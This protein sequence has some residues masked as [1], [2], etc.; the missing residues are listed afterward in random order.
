MRAPRSP[1]LLLAVAALLGPNVLIAQGRVIRGTVVDSSSG[2]PISAANVSVRGTTL[3]ASTGADGRFTI[4]NVPQGDVPVIVRRIGYRAREVVARSGQ[5]EIRVAMTS[6]P[7]QLD[8]VVV[9][10]QATAIERRNLPTAVATVSADEVARVSSQSF[11]HALQGKIPGAVI[12][13]NSGAP[14]GG[15]QVRM[16]GV[17]SINAASEPLYVV[18]G[19][20]VSN[21]A[22]PSNQNAVTNAAGGSNPSLDQDAQVNRVAD[23]NPNDIETVEV[24]KGASASAIYGSRAS[25]GVVLIT[26]K[27]GR[28]G[29][30]EFR[31][32]QRFGW[33]Q[34]SNK[35][36][37][38][39]FNSLAEAVDVWGPS[40]A[41]Y[42]QPGVSYDHEEE[43]AGNRPLSSETLLD[44]SGGGE[45]TRY[46]LSGAWKD[47]GGIIDNTGFERQSL[48]ANIQQQFGSRVTLD[49]G[50]NIIRTLAGRGLTNNDNTT[51]SFYMTL[52]FTPSFVNLRR[53]ATD[54]FPDNPFAASNPLETAALM[55]NHEIVWRYIGS[56]RLTVDAF[57]SQTQN[58]RFTAT[59]GA[60]YFAQKNDLLFP[61]EL[62][63]ED[64][65]GQPGTSL[66]SNSDNLNLNFSANG[67]HTF[68]PV[69]WGLRATTS[70]GL[71]FA[72]RDLNVSR[73]VSRSLVGGLEIVDAGTSVRVREF[74]QRV[75]DFGMF[76][77]EEVLLLGERLLLTAGLLADRS[78]V[79][80]DDDK[81]YLYP[82]VAASYRIPRLLRWLDELKLR[83][84]YG[85]TGNQ[86]L[87]GQKFTPL[88]ATQNLNGLPTL[89]VE[90]TI[91]ADNLRPERQRELEGGFDATFA[92]NRGTLEFSVF[93]KTVSD[94]LLERT[95][96]ASTGFTTH[97]FNGGRLRT[98]GV[99]VGLGVVPI[100]TR[101][102]QWVFRSTYFSNRSKIVDL[103]VPTFRAGGFGTALGAFQI[104]EGASPTQIV[105]NDT[106][107]SG[108]DTVR[109]IADANPD[110][111]MSF[112]SDLTYKRFRLSG[113]LDWQQGGA[114]I[115]LTKFLYD[116]GQ[117]TADYAVPITVGGQQ[118]TVG[119]HRLAVWPR[120]TA[121]YVEDGSFV[122]LRELTLSYDVPEQIVGRLW[123]QA[124]SVQLSVSGRNLI[125]WTDYTGLDPEVSNFGN[126][127]IARQI[128]VAPFPPS[129]SFWFGVQ[130]GF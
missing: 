1:L 60:D 99:E 116:L 105:G 12:Q 112:S 54:T 33:Y 56:G 87:Y 57:N 75:E 66:L 82:K 90:G 45:R 103:P 22:I 51:V 92:D 93:Q 80:S 28:S 108:A 58:L 124:R 126:Q 88:A 74:R 130:V 27:R 94:L 8:V 65:D 3:G 44:F 50:S 47:D 120:Q 107:P 23:L 64:D 118:T 40:A 127:N 71:N 29:R 30:P 19:V 119:A 37:A 18:D 41:N 96:A 16:R 76:A 59:A 111:V 38:R 52:P 128:D 48:R 78:S 9:S 110:F 15:V 89:V 113:L 5:E 31:L 69:R 121:V 81:L 11:E 43:L 20:V 46:Y 10:G 17:T 14:G 53:T 70:F 36:G 25:N 13:T 123:N 63:F 104:E 91:A 114:V 100:Q 39:K 6:D 85:E 122:K 97:I 86:P 77:Q 4:A 95:L 61:P 106:L 72:T 73:M 32:T 84:A 68:T 67:V 125:T 83:A 98:N 26:T 79:N 115:N 49:A 102:L 55:K 109:K 129:R 42:F 34:L 35:L 117:N 7:L 101:D 62:Q 24:L 2:A 21:V